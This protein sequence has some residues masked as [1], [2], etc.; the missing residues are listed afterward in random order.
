MTRYKET[1]GYA[2]EAKTILCNQGHS[3]ATGTN[4]FAKDDG[5]CFVDQSQTATTIIYPVS[6]LHAG[7]VINAFR[8]VGA[9]GATSGNAT[10][11]DASLRKVTKGAGA[12]TDAEIGAITQVSAEADAALDEEKSSLSD[13]VAT[14]YQYYVLVT[15]TTA[16]NAAND[17]SL[18]GVEV[19]V[20]Q[21]RP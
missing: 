2:N 7:D 11:V 13:I 3:G 1:T 4:T 15:I 8:V 21:D 5:T 14:D 19:D 9:I 20:N 16:A 10:T 6:G 12:V 17:V 18:T